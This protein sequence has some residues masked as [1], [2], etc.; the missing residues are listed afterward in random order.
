MVYLSD[1][2]INGDVYLQITSSILKV[3]GLGKIVP[4]ISGTDYEFYPTNLSFSAGTGILTLQRNGLSSLTTSLDGRYLTATSPV[5]DINVILQNLGG[6]IN[7]L[8]Q[9]RNYIS[10]AIVLSGGAFT[11]NNDGTLFVAAGHGL[12]KSSDTVNGD[13]IHLDWE[14][15]GTLPLTDNTTNYIYVE[16][17]G[18][19]PQIVA[20]TVERT[21]LNTNI[22][23][24]LVYREGAVAHLYGQKRFYGANHSQLIARRLQKT[25]P[26][27]REGGALIGETG[28]RNLTVTAGA[29]WE[30][31]DRFITPSIDTSAS[32]IFDY[33]YRDGVGGWTKQT[34]QTQINNTQYDDGSGTLATLGNNRYGSHWVYINSEGQVSIVFGR[35]NV[36]QLST[37]EDDAPPSDIPEVISSHGRLIGR[38]IIQKNASTFAD[39]DSAF[40]TV[41]TPSGTQDH[42]ELSGIQ[43]GT[44]GE[45]YHLNSARYT[46]LTSLTQGSILFSG[47]SSVVSQDNSNL[48][49][50]DTNKRLGIGTTAPTATLDVNGTGN[51]T[52]A[53]TGTS[54]T[55]SSY[56]RSQFGIVNSGLAS[57]QGAS[58]GLYTYFSGGG[59]VAAYADDAGT[60]AH[61]NLYSGGTLGLR[62]NVG[63]ATTLYGA[64][65]GTS[66][67]F[68][69]SVTASSIIKSGGTSTQFLK[70]DGSVDS[71]TY[72][73]SASLSGYVPYTGATTSVNLGSQTLTTT[74]AVGTGALT[75]TSGT[76][77]GNS[78]FSKKIILDA[79]GPENL[80]KLQYG[81]LSETVGSA[82]TILGNNISAGSTS[83]TVRRN[84]NSGDNGNF[85]N[86]RYDNGISFHTGIQSTLEQDVPMNINERMTIKPNG[87]IA[88]QNGN[89]KYGSNGIFYWGYDRGY[90]TY[91]VD[92]VAMRT[93]AANIDLKLGAGSYIPIIIKG[94]GSAT[95]I[96]NLLSG[97]SATFSGDVTIGGSATTAHLYLNSTTR[98]QIVAANNT[99]LEFHTGATEMA[100]F[101]AGGG[102]LLINTTTDAGYK[103]DVNGTSRFTGVLTAENVI[104]VNNVGGDAK[105]NFFRT[106]GNQYSFQHDAIRFYLYNNTTTGVPLAVKNDGT[107]GIGTENP[108]EKLE[109]TGNTLI[110]NN[111]FYKAKSLSGT[112]YAL[113]GI[114]SGN[115]IQIG[116]I[117]YTSAGLT[118]AGGDYISFTTGG[119]SGTERMK[120]LNTG[121]VNIASGTWKF[122][123][124]GLFEWGSNRGYLTWGTGYA[125][126]RSRSGN[127]LDLGTDS[128]GIIMTLAESGNAGIGTN[129][130]SQK[131][132]VE[133][134]NPIIGILNSSAPAVD[135]STG[136]YFYNNNGGSQDFNAGI[137]S[138]YRGGTNAAARYLEFYAGGGSTT[139]L[140]VLSG[141][142][143]VIINN[144]LELQK[145]SGDPLVTIFKNAKSEWDGGVIASDTTTVTPITWLP[146]GDFISG[147]RLR[148]PLN[149]TGIGGTV[150]AQKDLKILPYQYG[151]A[152]EYSGVVE[153]WVG[154]WSIHKGILNDVE[155]NSTGWGAVQWVGND[156]DTGGL[157][158]TARDNT[159]YSGSLKYGEMSVEQFSGNNPLGDMH[160]RLPSISNNFRFI[161]GPRGETFAY[162]EINQY[163]VISSMYTSKAADYGTSFK[164]LN[165]SASNAEQFKLEHSGAL[166]ILSNSRGDI[167]TQN[168]SYY[169]GIGKDPDVKL[170]VYN[171]SS[172]VQIRVGNSSSTDMRM[173][174]SGGVGIIGTYSNSELIYKTNNIG[175]IALQTNGLIRHKDITYKDTGVT[176][177]S[178]GVGDV[179]IPLAEA[180]CTVIFEFHVYGGAG[181]S[182]AIV[183]IGVDNSVPVAD[184]SLISSLGITPIITTTL[185]NSNTELN[186]NVEVEAG[187]NIWWNYRLIGGNSA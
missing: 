83:A 170:D 38:I 82:S 88:I 118:V 99:S 90:L 147:L 81:S 163:G 14:E 148:H 156:V 79:Q 17:N 42:N 33:Y 115:T 140:M 70:A 20:D 167:V 158:F 123:S 2:D 129:V 160:F 72:L 187:E 53:L 1:L 165:T 75:G 35:I 153:C 13:I 164:T 128:S 36:T 89:W 31:V 73:T 136:L 7:N 84:V 37:A 172:D 112:T 114:T 64:L 149:V 166:T 10:S 119:A 15:N 51:F 185:I 138:I 45:Y 134:T 107:V 131:L 122:T 177:M 50:D 183:L 26:F 62:V 4:A 67:S 154:E 143:N 66:A 32:D 30:G 137:K 78:Y 55:M 56:S 121:E 141:A 116:A 106:G 61:L 133:S 94:D 39:V 5:Q 27:A 174:A 22:F 9:E 28:V 130:P 139:P 97:T 152:I 161:Y 157:R 76:F 46:G 58:G 178:S 103:L 60:A 18:G 6:T 186:V 41:F 100:R 8:R 146:G 12:I 29:F 180:S 169:F 24:G 184:N 48:F 142:G 63:G 34:G 111:S 11:N 126:L 21:D 65:T 16:Y 68:I 173:L 74:G 181:Y 40:E 179:V 3:D 144:N 151:F 127:R 43:G 105:I 109:I 57:F 145:P 19:A 93:S 85:I 98:N 113:A 117:D 23:L 155:G 125:A 69:S 110:S 95:Q 47:A 108:T 59:I 171:N 92:Y 135:L 175:H 25:D 176:T 80:I 77:S 54:A 102:N 120:I 96:S 182:A 91:D 159:S 49:W 44:A 162:T 132:S 150:S 86:I 124:G 104:N 168:N 101:S 87:E 52:G 71:S